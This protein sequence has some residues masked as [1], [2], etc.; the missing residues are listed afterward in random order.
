M[1]ISIKPLED[2]I[3]VQTA[4]AV[5]ANR[6]RDVLKGRHQHGASPSTRLQ[7]KAGCIDVLCLD[8]RPDV[9]LGTSVL[10]VP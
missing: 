8:D 10:S 4:E 9:E 2:R 1:S 6:R 3:V 5:C 7:Q